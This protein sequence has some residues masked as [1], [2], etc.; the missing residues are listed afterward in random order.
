VLAAGGVA[1][2]DE[3]RIDAVIATN[4]TTIVSLSTPLPVHIT[5]LTAWVEDGVVN[6]AKDVYG[7][8]AKLLAA[9]NGNSLAW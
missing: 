8:D 1:G 4:M 2:W 7:H 5:Y 3:R 9:L 6:F